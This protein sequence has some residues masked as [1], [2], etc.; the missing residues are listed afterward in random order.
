MQK[1]SFFIT[2]LFA[3]LFT[4]IGCSSENTYTVT[5]KDGIRHVHNRAPLWG[6]EPKVALEF[7]QRFGDPDTE[8]ERYWLFRPNSVVRDENGDIYILD[9][10]RRVVKYNKDGQFL[11]SFGREGQGPGEML[12]PQKM[13]IGP[14]GNLY[15]L[16]MSRL[17]V[18]TPEGRELK[19]IRAYYSNVFYLSHSGTVI[20]PAR[21]ERWRLAGYNVE[22]CRVLSLY[23]LEGNLLTEFGKPKAFQDYKQMT[24]GNF[25]DVCIGPDNNIFVSFDT[26]NRIEKYSPSGELLIKSDRPLDYGLGLIKGRS[27]V[28]PFFNK[29]TR[30]IAVDGKRRIW[31]NTYTKQRETGEK[32]VDNMNFEI[33]DSNCVLLGKLPLPENFIR[34]SIYND[35]LYL[36]DASEEMCV[37]EYKIIEK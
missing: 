11:T 19:R 31:I 10:V 14:D 34:M 17:T 16:D 28:L 1:K 6:N 3:L 23:D 20:Y 36:I 26:Q 7:V 12:V 30:N 27:S 8:D 21:M 13:E 18:L 25:T 9:G 32:P 24:M 2:F 33:F 5:I 22:K 4:I 35:R 15:I 37:Y 29:V